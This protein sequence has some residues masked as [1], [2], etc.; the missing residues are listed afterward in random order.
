MGCQTSDL[1]LA[2]TRMME[3]NMELMNASK[4]GDLSKVQE[5]IADLD[6]RG[7]DVNYIAASALM[8]A[9]RYNHREIVFTLLSVKGINVN[10]QGYM[11]HNA[12]MCACQ[13]GNREI[14]LALLS[15]DDIQVN[16]Y[17]TTSRYTALMEACIVGNKEIILALLSVNGIDVNMQSYNG[18]T[19]LMEACRNYHREIVLALLSVSDIDVN[20]RDTF[21]G[22][23][24]LMLACMRRHN[25]NIA[26]DLLLDRRVNRHITDNFGKTALMLA[27]DINLPTVV[28]RIEEMDRADDRMP[29]LLVHHHYMYADAADATNGLLHPTTSAISKALVITGIV[30][31][32]CRYIA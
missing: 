29:M 7:V 2:D 28:T 21:S 1:Q 32:I 13:R 17:L 6:G 8:R 15:M 10:A 16:L 26:L 14:V 18:D 4:K 27:R 9:C 22:H 20:L 25:P 12:L 24:A 30:H 3:D 19:A 31:I 5:L 11:G 23:T